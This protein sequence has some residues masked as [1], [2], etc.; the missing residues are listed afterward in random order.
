V[1]RHD[2]NSF[3]GYS[4]VALGILVLTS[5]SVLYGIYHNTEDRIA[6]SKLQ[7]IR[8]IF[9]DI[10]PYQYTNDIYNDPIEV[11]QPAYLGT[12]QAV[13]IYRIRNNDIPLG[14]IIHPVIAVGYE[15]LIELGIGI[16][17]EGAITGVRITSED[18]TEGM[19]DQIHQDKTDWI[20]MFNG[21][22]YA[23]LPVD[24]WRVKSENGYFDQISGATITSRSVINAIR[25]A[26]NYHNFAK[27]DLYFQ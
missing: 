20:L 11:I 23:N 19:G 13:S 27:D 17:K 25:N 15:S 2:R 18:E 6:E 24:Q 22:S 4:I 8:R 9:S 14:V 1:S 10:I 5:I 12:N 16:S 3:P 26:L 7:V 21:K